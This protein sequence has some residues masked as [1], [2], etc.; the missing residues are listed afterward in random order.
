MSRA[1]LARRI[2]GLATVV[3]AGLGMRYMTALVWTTTAGDWALLRLSWSAHPERV[4]QCRRLTDEELAARPAHMRMRLECQGMFARYLLTVTIDDRVVAA[5]T[6]RGGGL[7]HDRPMH[8]FTEF[9]FAAG[10]RH[11]QIGLTRLDSAAT[12]T[13]SRQPSVTAARDTLMGAREA[14]EADERTRRAS[15][16]IPPRLA[17]DTL[18]PLQ[19][20]RVVLVTYDGERR[21][22]V[23]Q[24][25]K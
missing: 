6:V 9:R 2:G 22:L 7:R 15:E 21:R 23:A 18:I 1:V 10:V 11:V 8:L 20:R 24:T 25:E 17:L 5:D 13:A 12:D 16:A 3:L 14:R 4:E 19:P